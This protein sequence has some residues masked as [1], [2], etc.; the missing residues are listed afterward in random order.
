[1]E[2][3]KFTLAPSLLAGAVLML[4][5]WPTRQSGQRMLRRWGVPEPTGS[6]LREAVRYLFHRRIL[7]V[8]LFAIVP[9]LTA[10]FRS[11]T[12][13]DWLSANIFLQLVAAMLIAELIATL[14]PVS[15]VRV[16]SLDRR[17]GRDLVPGWAI[18]VTAVLAVL[19]AGLAVLALLADSWANRYAAAAPDEESA[20]TLSAP[21][22]WLVLA[23]VA[24][25]L[26]TVALVV[27]LAARR[28]SV[29]D[30]AVDAALRIRTA[31]VAVA[32]GFGSLAG[33]VAQAQGRLDSL[34]LES[35]DA[36]RDPSLPAPPSWL[37]DDLGQGLEIAAF[38]VFLF[39]LGFWIQLAMPS[40]RSLA[41]ATR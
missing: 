41:P 18:A 12:G 20:T 39:A 31:R 21:P 22:G 8:V 35:L 37:T 19:A 6:Q 34:V 5:L 10:S 27:F 25:S 11:P 23:G 3:L 36:R 16:A 40:R 2:W 9:S 17:R 4:V 29:S 38:A 33:L 24:A 14:R 15:G 13:D 30:P 7:Y 28:P 26:A 32:I 1:V